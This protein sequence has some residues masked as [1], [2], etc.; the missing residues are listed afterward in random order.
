[1]RPAP[2]HPNGVIPRRDNQF[3]HPIHH[4]LL[5]LQLFA[6]LG[7]W[8]K[9]KSCDCLIRFD[10]FQVHHPAAIQFKARDL[11]FGIT[12]D[13]D[14]VHEPEIVE[15]VVVS[16]QDE[17]RIV[18]LCIAEEQVMIFHADAVVA[19]QFRAIIG[20]RVSGQLPV[21]FGGGIIFF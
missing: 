2:N 15:Q 6:R 14:V 8:N 21:G 11:V 18:V 1:M 17:G 12:R 16:I 3:W 13:M 9:R 10:E 4:K 20:T 19:I 5:N 7:Q